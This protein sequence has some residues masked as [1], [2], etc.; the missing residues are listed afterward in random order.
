M[1]RSGM[2][3]V[4]AVAAAALLVGC[5]D[6]PAYD[7]SVVEAALDR[8]PPAPLDELEV[9]SA[10]CPAAELADPMETTCTVEVDGTEV[11]VAVRLEGTGGDDVVLTAT[12]QLATIDPEAAASYV[13]ELL[14]ED[15][16]AAEVTCNDGAPIPA[17]AGRRVAC[18]LALGAVVDEV[19]LVVADTDGTL[20]LGR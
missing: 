5:A 6:E 4:A 8:T 19:E 17:L 15:V 20:E 3:L 1:K 12:P 18:E 9:G 14:A 13:R 10:R 11:E 2:L 7:P 16:R